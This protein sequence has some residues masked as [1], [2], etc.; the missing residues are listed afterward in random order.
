MARRK[1]NIAKT[2]PQAGA[3]TAGAVAATF[4]SNKLPIGNDKIKAAIPMV[5]GIFLLGQKGMVADLGAGMIAGGGANVA[6]SFGLNGVYLGGTE[7]E[8][9]VVDYTSDNEVSLE[10]AF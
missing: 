4:V 2:L 9:N 7:Q 1:M 6:Q 5:V 8:I 3:L 10:D